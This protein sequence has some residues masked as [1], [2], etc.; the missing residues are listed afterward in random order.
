MGTASPQA[1]LRRGNPR[2]K[3]GPNH[4]TGDRRMATRKPAHKPETGPQR[5]RVLAA[6]GKPTPTRGRKGQPRGDRALEETL[7]AWGKGKAHRR[8]EVDGERSST[9]TQG[10]LQA[11]LPEGNGSREPQR[12]DQGVQTAQPE[13]NLLGPGGSATAREISGYGAPIR[14]DTHPRLHRVTS[15][16]IDRYVCEDYGYGYAQGFREA[17]KIPHGAG[18]DR[19]QTTPWIIA[20]GAI[21]LAIA[22]WLR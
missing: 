20:I 14:G 8:L 19:R 22:G 16:G 10:G 9:P 11:R 21:L 15:G 6:V 13:G 1:H 3:A 12:P 2:A 4:P 5:S 7:R 18:S 17:L